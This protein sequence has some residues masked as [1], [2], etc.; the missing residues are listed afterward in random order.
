MTK[1]SSEII[2]YKG[3]EYPLYS[4]PLR[5]YLECEKIS[6]R[7][8]SSAAF[9][10]YVGEWKIEKGRLFLTRIGCSRDTLFSLFNSDEPVFASWFS[11]TLKIA[12]GEMTG[13]ELVRDTIYDYYLWVKIENGLVR[14]RQIHQH[15]DDDPVINF[16]RYNGLRL[17]KLIRGDVNF[18]D[19]PYFFCHIYVRALLEFFCLREFN[20]SIQIPQFDQ[21]RDLLEEADSF[22]YHNVK[23]L[24]TKEF[25]A[26][27]LFSRG[28]GENEGK[29]GSFSRFIENILL[30]DFNNLTIA[31]RKDYRLSDIE[32]NI[33]L[34]NPD[35]DYLNWA[36]NEVKG[37]S[38][39]PHLVESSRILNR[40]EAF[41][42]RRLNET[43]FEY[44]PVTTRLSY[45]LKPKTK[46]IN[47]TK[48][49]KRH[50]VAYDQ[51]NKI[52]IPVF[53]KNSVAA[54]YQYL[55]D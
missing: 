3:R 41:K 53:P 42:T 54:G 1:Q 50:N 44:E 26:I 35:Y 25:V 33:Y 7:G 31:R 46:E 12:V 9:R 4:A 8:I 37:F 48:F 27:E 11:G 20:K 2:E 10:G 14:E 23:F 52:Y 39:P 28:W 19:D 22:S 24:V 36:I 29:A 16:G 40:L 43:I 18:T 45:A 13:L 32:G 17:S 6:M 21:T 51:V 5:G 47:L 30:Q 55:L 38:V 34:L 49:E 15:F